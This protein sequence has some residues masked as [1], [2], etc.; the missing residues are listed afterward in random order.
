VFLSTLPKR[1]T[2]ELFKTTKAPLLGSPFAH[3]ENNDNTNNDNPQA[4]E[5]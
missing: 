4:D 5:G 1:R 2:I 3:S